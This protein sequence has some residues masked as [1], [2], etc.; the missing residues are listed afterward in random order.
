MGVASLGRSLAD[1]NQRENGNEANRRNADKDESKHRPCYTAGGVAQ[2][3][4]GGMF[5]IV[6]GS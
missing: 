2:F 6:H 1:R 5:A 3:K 4:M